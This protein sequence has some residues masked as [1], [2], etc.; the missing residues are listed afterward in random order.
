MQMTGA[1]EALRTEFV[2]QEQ[3]GTCFPSVKV[4]LK[5]FVYSLVLDINSSVAPAQ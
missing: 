4:M 1:L 5:C 2:M 3:S